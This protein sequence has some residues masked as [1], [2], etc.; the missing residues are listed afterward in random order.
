MSGVSTA[1]SMAKDHGLSFSPEIINGII[2]N[3]DLNEMTY[4]ELAITWGATRRVSKQFC[5]EITR[6]FGRKVLP[7]MTVS[8][9][10]GK[11]IQVKDET[12]FQL[13]VYTTEAD[14]QRN[15]H[16]SKVPT[17]AQTWIELRFLP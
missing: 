3:L 6:I 14:T 1:G 2:A 17:L 5:S 9:N 10:L 7:E 16:S 12:C 15:R 4:T 11:Y 13:E 8:Y